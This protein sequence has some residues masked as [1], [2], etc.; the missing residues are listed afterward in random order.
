MNYEKDKTRTS[1]RNC[2]AGF[3]F[4][5]RENV[6]A[7]Q[8]CKKIQITQNS[9][10]QLKLSDEN[11][12]HLFAQFLLSFRPSCEFCSISLIIVHSDDTSSYFLHLCITTFSTLPLCFGRTFARVYTIGEQE[13]PKLVQTDVSLR[14]K[15]AIKTNRRC[16][17]VKLTRP[18]NA[19]HPQ[20][21]MIW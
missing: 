5:C 7:N 15:T 18:S 13:M 4:I 2:R 3:H 6:H 12:F 11:L 17:E 10:T 19:W 21:R 14:I 9:C 1:C 16:C 8:S 20:R